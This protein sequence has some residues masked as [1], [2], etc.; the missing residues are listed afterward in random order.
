MR[1][2]SV[3]LLSLFMYFGA[4]ANHFTGGHLRYEYMGNS[5]QY[6]IYLTLYKTCE[7]TAIDFPTF[8][9]IYAESKANTTII[10]KN[11]ALISQDT[12]KAYCPGT[13]TSCNSLTAPYPGY[14]AAVY[15]ETVTFPFTAP[16]WKLVFSN[17]SRSLN[18]VN[19]QGAS[20]TSFYIDAP[21][22]NSNHIN[23]SP[24]LPDIPPHVLFVNDS[25]SIPL[26]STDV[27]GDTVKYRFVNPESASG[28][29]I[30]YYSG[31]SP[32]Q[33]FGNGGLCYIR[34][35]NTMVL[36]SAATGKYTL[37]LKIE[38]YRQGTY[39]G[40]T[41]RDFVVTCVNSTPGS[42]L[43]I[44]TPVNRNNVYTF[45]CPGRSNY[46]ALNFEDAAT[47][48]SVY[49]DIITPVISGFTFNTSATNGIGNATGYISWTTPTSMDPT[50]LK[51]FDFIV[52]VRDNACRM[53]GKATYVY[54]VNTR[55]CSADSVWPGDANTDKIANLYDPLAVA[56][57]YKD[58]GAARPNAS[59]AWAAQYCNY[60]NGSFL[61][62]IDI[63]HADCNG[64]GII[65]TADLHAIALN[66]GKVHAKGGR[67]SQKTTAGTDLYFDHTGIT[68]NPD[69]TVSIK[70]LLGS[71]TAPIAN[72]Y[73]IAANLEID[74]LA[75]ATP[76]TITF[77][78]NWVGDSTNT[79]RFVKDLS[80]TSLDWAFAKTN[81]QNINGHGQ[82]AD[83]EF[84][85]P[86]TTPNG[87]LVTLSY[88][89]VRIINK[90]GQDIFDFNTQ[91]DTFYVWE[92]VHIT[93]VSTDIR[94]LQLYPNPGGNEV[95]LSLQSPDSY[96][97]MVDIS[98]ITGKTIITNSYS[99]QE[100]KNAFT[101]NTRG[102][103][104]GMYLVRVTSAEAGFTQTLR[105]VKK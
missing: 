56:M 55:L 45:T 32:S 10:N 18:I 104:A 35:N 25:I 97:L 94:K 101:L 93:T 96:A 40:Y 67:S 70:M 44:P 75:L 77:P 33:P 61:S 47:G 60:W 64:D 6:K 87:T 20:G 34:D 95:S 72:F 52:N 76:P 90:D 80:A 48:D 59:T 27:D 84:K 29:N 41:T 98:D 19:L 26:S 71:P 21:L 88:D 54:R 57:A 79:L 3:L 74:G 17:S 12:I 14:I 53:I 22:N 7:S 68:A 50:S 99:L 5:L 36:K 85:I 23:S 51:F 82:I 105:F 4:M 69:S 65:D 58:T 92:P 73:G 30:P 28:T 2:I 81:K 31:Y 91:T 43:S 66:Y 42:K 24:V 63:K 102:L 13:T 39:I 89:K 8:V 15:S 46:L 78:V 11:L 49:M 37:T 9:N 38:E 1:K 16:D 62:N 83:I 100:G 86:A 103:P